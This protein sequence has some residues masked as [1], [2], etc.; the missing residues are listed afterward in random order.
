MPKIKYAATIILSRGPDQDP[1]IYL[2]RR[3]PEIKFFGDYWVF[4]GGNVSD[5]DYHHRSDDLQQAFYRCAIREAFEECN[6]LSATLGQSFSAAEKQVISKDL[7]DSPASWKRFLASFDQTFSQLLPVFRVTTPPFAPVL[8]DTQFMLVRAHDGES[9]DI[10]N[11]E[12]VEDCFVKPAVAIEAWLKGEMKIAP[13]VLML[14]KLIEQQGLTG[15]TTLAAEA[16]TALDNGGLHQSYFS[17][18]IFMAPL[19]TDTIPPA[20][21]TNTLIVGNA[22]IY[23]VDPASPHIEEQNRLFRQLDKMIAEGKQLEC[24]LLTHH[25][26]DHVGA[27]N[28]LS[29]RYRIPVRA[30]ELCYQ[31]IPE[32]YIKGQA[33]QDGDI[34]ELGTA[35]DGSDNWQL[36]VMHTPGHAVDHLCFLDSRYQSAIVGDML[37]TVQTILISPPEGHMRTYLDSLE[38][39]LS[40]GIKT[41]YP[42]HGPAHRDGCSLIRYFIQHRNEREQKTIRALDK[43]PASLDELLPIVYDDVAESVFPIAKHSLLAVLIKLEEDGICLQIDGSWSLR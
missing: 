39:L 27:V 3:A 28:A 37:S 20:T 40:C 41:L 43:Q 30:H 23:I 24:I 35:P 29:H 36:R 12:L 34:L 10:D 5:I 21:T 32:G 7:S 38:H 14:L 25:H 1:E 2:A 42:A 18:G 19:A 22:K 8:Y 26:S 33:L 4:P 17:P 6:I 11:Y 13:P 16:Q 9:P 31:R 15:F